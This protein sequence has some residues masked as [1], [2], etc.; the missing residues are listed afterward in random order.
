[1]IK[2]LQNLALFKL[3]WVACVVFAA[4][5]QPIAS[6]LSVTAVAAIHL[7]RVPAPRPDLGIRVGDVRPVDLPRRVL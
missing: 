3:G 2:T 4:T 5:G 1:M 7:T 6:L